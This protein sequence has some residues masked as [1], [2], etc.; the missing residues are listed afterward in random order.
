[1][2]Q[3]SRNSAGFSSS[4]ALVKNLSILDLK[5]STDSSLVVSVILMTF[6]LEQASSVS[7]FLISAFSAS[8]SRH[9]AWMRSPGSGV[10]SSAVGLPLLGSKVST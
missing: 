3:E 8:K 9:L 7:S 10:G 6:L 1:M 5:G 2:T 4:P